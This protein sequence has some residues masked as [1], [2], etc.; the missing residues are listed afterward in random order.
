M[1]EEELS[2]K[3]L[4]VIDYYFENGQDWLKAYRAVYPKAKE[5]SVRT[6]SAKLSKKTLKNLIFSEKL[7]K[8]K[9]AAERKI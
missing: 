1:S 9:Q 7:T 6:E 3:H 5:N 2:D 8:V 4:N